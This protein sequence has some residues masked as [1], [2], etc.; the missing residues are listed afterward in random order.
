MAKK[1]WR[2]AKKRS[3]EQAK[4]R[5]DTTPDRTASV[6]PSSHDSTGEEFNESDSGTYQ[7][8]MDEMRCILY[9]H[10]GGPACSNITPPES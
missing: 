3:K 2:D 6:T 5:D 10:G 7:Q 9:F 8:D 1:D 4:Q